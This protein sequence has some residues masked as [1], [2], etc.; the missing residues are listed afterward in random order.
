MF[1][2]WYTF[3]FF[4]NNI[5]TFIKVNLCWYEYDLKLNT[6]D[7]RGMNIFCVEIKS[8][9]GALDKYNIY[10]FISNP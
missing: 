3:I 5:V 7:L 2:T 4:K 10:L 8:I 6:F 1:L 9:K